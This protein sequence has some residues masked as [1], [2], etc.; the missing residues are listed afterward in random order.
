MNNWGVYRG[1]NQ[2][3]DGANQLPDPPPWRAFMRTSSQR[4]STFQ[5]SLEEVELV[6][7]ALYLRRPLLITGKPGI[8]KSTLAYSVAHELQ[9]GEVLRWPI[10]TRSTLN[11]GIYSYDAIGRLQEA[12]FLRLKGNELDLPDIGKFLRLGP[13]GTA[14]LPSDSPRVLLID[15]IDKSDVDLPNDLLHVFEEGEFSVPELA[16]L[17]DQRNVSVLTADGKYAVIED[18]IVRCRTFPFVVFTSNGEREFPAAFLRRCL[19]LTMQPPDR[20]KLLDIVNAHLG[21]EANSNLPQEIEQIIDN[22]LQLRG[23]REL[24]TD[25]LLNA[26]YLSTQQVEPLARPALVDAIFKSLSGAA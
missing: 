15:E 9:L 16:R 1:D 19:R 3:H 26:I 7:A 23:E 11:E 18:G 22:F 4:G 21:V 24:A 8:G 2:P 17:A 20:Q 10:T 13:L 25:Q 6:N 14:L 5:A 12:N